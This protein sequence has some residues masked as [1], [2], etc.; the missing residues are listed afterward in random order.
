MPIVQISS[1]MAARRAY[2]ASSMCK[3]SLRLCLYARVSIAFLARVSE[4]ISRQ[5][6]SRAQNEVAA[7]APQ[8]SS[9]LNISFLGVSPSTFRVPLV[10]LAIHRRTSQPRWRHAPTRGRSRSH[11]HVPRARPPDVLS[12]RGNASSKRAIAWILRTRGH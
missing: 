8:N 1:C 7:R 9:E 6:G 5:S 3:N 10:C 2:S 12:P 4:H 11:A